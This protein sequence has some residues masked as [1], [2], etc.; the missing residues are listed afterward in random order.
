MSG[1]ENV[2]NG[3]QTARRRRLAIAALLLLLLGGGLWWSTR[4]KVD[5]RFVGTWT[6]AFK[7]DRPKPK[8]RL[9]IRA[10]GIAY[11]VPDRPYRCRIVD[12]EIRLLDYRGNDIRAGL[13]H[14]VADFNELLGIDQTIIRLKIVEATGDSLRVR[15]VLRVSGGL[16]NHA[17]V[18]Y[19]R[20]SDSESPTE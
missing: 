18:A 10:D 13:M 15:Q 8:P 19:V 3:D 9:T 16:Q 11:L 17:V 6:F 12:N 7:P 5:P 1:F 20:M 4:P 2:T 14:L